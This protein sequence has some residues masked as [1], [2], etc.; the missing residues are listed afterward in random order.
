MFQYSVIGCVSKLP[1]Q[2][3]TEYSPKRQ[4]RKQ[5]DFP[6]FDT[7]LSLQC[8]SFFFAFF[9][10]TV[11]QV[12]LLIYLF[13]HADLIHFLL[14]SRTSLPHFSELWGTSEIFILPHL[15]SNSESAIWCLVSNLLIPSAKR[16]GCFNLFFFFFN[17]NNK[18]VYC[19]CFIN[20]YTFFISFNKAWEG[21]FVLRIGDLKKRENKYP[22]VLPSHFCNP[23]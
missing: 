21:C 2:Q 1:L 7:L 17:I 22:M 8:I 12:L 4:F 13:S 3:L 20:S 14:L 15:G 6:V 10:T 19:W 5:L 23:Q 18:V 16:S 9:E 11:I